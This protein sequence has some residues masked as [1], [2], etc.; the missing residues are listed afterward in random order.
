MEDHGGMRLRAAVFA[1]CTILFAV[2]FSAARRPPVLDLGQ[3]LDQIRLFGEVL[4]GE[5]P[6]LR[7]TW[8]G[9]N[10]LGYLPLGVASLVAPVEW[11][12]RVALLLV[13]AC[14]L[15]AVH[16]IGAWLGRPVAVSVMASTLLLGCVFYAGMFNFLLGVVSLAYWV[17]ELREEQRD[18]PI[19]RVYFSTLGGIALAYLAHG[20]WLLAGGFAV[21]TYS[22]LVHFRPRETLARALA[23]ATFQPLAFAWANQLEASGWQTSSKMILAP[24]GRLA[25]PDTAASIAYGGLR[26]P[27]EPLLLSL[28]LLWIA[29]GLWRAAREEWRGIDRFLAIFGGLCLAG[30]L[31]LPDKVDRTILFAWRWGAPGLLALLFAVPPPLAP[32]RLAAGIAGAALLLQLGVSFFAWRDFGRREMAGFEESLAA[33]PPEARLLALDWRLE[34]PNFRL[35]PYF[36]MLAWAALERGAG[37]HFSFVDYPSSLVVRREPAVAYLRSDHLA[38]NPRALQPELLRGVTHMLVHGPPGV[39]RAYEEQSDILRVAAGRADWHLLAV[40]RAELERLLAARSAAI[41]T[42]PRP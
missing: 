30:A 39:A 34:S 8:L 16:A 19:V 6:E 41:A 2:V 9:S 4:A 18:R 32:R 37:T 5:H 36:Q 13:A 33:I 27:L 28:L 24:V 1:V 17:R 10:K 25:D 23:V 35:A 3:Q 11:L 26:G 21:A 14:W 42:Q 40:R 31:L 20:L 7:V 22:L 15:A 12:P 38:L 29:F